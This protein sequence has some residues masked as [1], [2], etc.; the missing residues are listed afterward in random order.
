MSST[1]PAADSFNPSLLAPLKDD[2]TGLRILAVHAHPDDESSKGAAT[3][4][5]YVARGARV[6]VASMTGGERGD[7]LNEALNNDAWAHRDLAG[8]RRAEMKQAAEI[9]GIEHRWIGFMDSGLPEGDPLPPLPYGSFATL[10]L[11]QAAAP[12]VRLVRDFKPHIILTYDEIGGYPHPDHIMTHRVSMEA[13]N[14]AGDADAYPGTGEPWDVSKIYY[15]RAFN[16]D[17][18]MAF[19]SYFEGAGLESPFA[20]LIAMSMEDDLEGRRP[21]VSRHQTTTRISSTDYLEKRDQALLSHR[22]Q[23]APD[24]IFFAV[25]SDL[26]RKIWPFEDYVLARSRV[27]SDLPETCFST[28]IDY[29]S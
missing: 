27:K 4:A 20:Q 28:G 24:S 29:N 11:E 9:L 26:Q 23:V 6:M 14:K 5:A 15:D 2:Y 22:S 19:H 17:R 18:V 25:S 1:E 12:L 3:M 8:V 7:I 10:P 21:P 16:L 13:F